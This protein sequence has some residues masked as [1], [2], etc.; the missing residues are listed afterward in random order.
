TPHELHI[1]TINIQSLSCRFLHTKSHP[2]LESSCAAPPTKFELCCGGEKR[3]DHQL[4]LPVRR[5]GFGD[6]VAIL[7][8]LLAVLIVRDPVQRMV[9]CGDVAVRIVGHLGGNTAIACQV[10]KKWMCL[11]AG[12]I[13]ACVRHGVCVCIS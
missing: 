11:S 10:T 3:P 7:P 8:A 12:A 6:L 1:S 13:R 4:C 5:D 2:P 9:R